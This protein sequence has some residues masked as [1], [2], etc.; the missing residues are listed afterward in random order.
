MWVSTFWSR[1]R[2]LRDEGSPD[3]VLL[4][5][6][7]THSFSPFF[8]TVHLELLSVPDQQ[9]GQAG[10]KVLERLI[11]HTSLPAGPREAS[12]PAHRE[13]T[14]SVISNIIPCVHHPVIMPH[15]WS[16]I[17]TTQDE[18]PLS[19]LTLHGH[20]IADSPACEWGVSIR[21]PGS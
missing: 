18:A 12:R 17:L 8:R 1:S 5:K 20:G 9:T 21:C 7:S 2:R 3:F 14:A 4:W 19:P 16:E 13:V 11:I 6:S 10:Q 15:R